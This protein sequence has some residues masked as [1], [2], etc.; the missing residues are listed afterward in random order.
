MFTFESLQ[1]FTTDYYEKS[2]KHN[3]ARVVY[4]WVERR[5]FWTYFSLGVRYRLLAVAA[6]S[7]SIR[8][9]ALQVVLQ[10]FATQRQSAPVR[11]LDRRKD[12][13]L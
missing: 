4:S 6:H 1:V 8:A 13:R 2:A 7:G 12:T 3:Y 11:T 9:L 10:V 5:A